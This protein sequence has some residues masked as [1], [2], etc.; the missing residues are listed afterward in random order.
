MAAALIVLNVVAVRAFYDVYRGQ[1]YSWRFAESFFIKESS[2]DQSAVLDRMRS[3]SFV[4]C[5]V[6]CD[7]LENCSGV[8][9]RD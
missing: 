2:L 8:A 3:R 7:M 9:F 5:C 1:C 4:E 6:A